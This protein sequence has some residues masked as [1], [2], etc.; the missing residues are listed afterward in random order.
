MRHHN[1]HPIPTAGYPATW[2]KG[3]LASLLVLLAAC[4]EPTET[5][6]SVAMPDDTVVAPE[7]RFDTEIRWTSYGIP[8]VKAN[9]WGS[10]GYGFAYATAK[11]AVC[12]IAKDVLMVNGELSRHFGAEQGNLQSDIFHR[13]VLD[14]TMIAGFRASQ[15][16]KA[17]EFSAGYI[18][19]YNR[20]INDHRQDLPESCAGA[21]WV[22]SISERDLDKLTI[23]VGIRYGLGRF[24][25]EMANAAPPGQ[26][27]ASLSTDFDIPAGIGSN[28]VAMGRDVTETGRGLLLGNPHYPWQGSSRFHMIHT[29]I[30]GELDVMG[31]SLYTT[32]RIAIGFNKDVAW[33]HTVSTGLRS[34]IYALELDP[35]NPTRYRYG[36]DYRDMQ[37]VTIEV[38][39]RNQEGGASVQS[40]TV[41]MTH[42][43]P[44]LVSNQLPWT[45]ER[46]YAIRDANLYNDRAAVTYDALNRA[47]NID[48][49]EAALSQQGVSWTNTIAAD[50][51]GTAFYA[52]IS[53]VPNVDAELIGRCQVPV[54]GV[55]RQ[56]V[57]LDGTRP[58]C[59]WQNTSASHIPGAMPP[60]NMPRIRR[61]DYVHNAND[62]YWLSTPRQPLEGF[63]P[64]IGAENAAVSLRTRA[65]LTFI[66]AALAKGQKMQA[67]DLQDMLFSHRHF[68]AELFLDEVLT[69]CTGDTVVSLEAAEVDIS[70]ACA[71]LAGWDRREDVDSRG[72]HVWREFWRQAARTQGLYAVPFDAAD[73]VNTPRALALDNNQVKQALRQALASSQKLFTDNQI[74]LDAPLGTLQFEPR[75][76]EMIPIPGGDGGAGM[77]SV[78][79]SQYRPGVGY[80]PIAHGNSYIQAVG[81]QQDGSVQANAILTYSQSEDPRSPH[82]ADQTRLYSDSQWISLPFYE[83]DIAADPNLLTLVLQE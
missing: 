30:P 4:A 44:L 39:V 13:A 37:P 74:A 23:G 80:S 11:D 45:P 24:Q 58:D 59:E 66:E 47:T 31:V 63:S 53:V 9:D 73:P 18:A 32:N 75:G 83:Q 81:W 34:T 64:I 57:I 1:C 77:W 22:S 19:G 82:F 67:Q 10:L 61:D 12:T 8:H 7:H 65:G 49:V 62:S 71:A 72:A 41:Y 17:S 3:T 43:G 28:A 56:L 38:P 50:R 69:L 2:L 42:Y 25:R 16:D 26:P 20:Y 51:D 40:H 55:P 5:G 54:D 46:A 36:D 68:G 27:V 6:S 79:T 52:D 33:T 29:T 70:A 15:S 78:I 76:N 35:T 48:D 14:D 21:T 60:D